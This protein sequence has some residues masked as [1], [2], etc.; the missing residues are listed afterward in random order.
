MNSNFYVVD[1]Y[2]LAQF[3]RLN[4]V[5]ALPPE[6]TSISISVDPLFL[7]LLL[8]SMFSYVFLKNGHEKRLTY[9]LMVFVFIQSYLSSLSLGRM[10]TKVKAC[11]QI[12]FFYLN[13]YAHVMHLITFASFINLKFLQ[14]QTLND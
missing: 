12:Q 2:S 1:F 13:I 14:S 3:R 11:N 6:S 5:K 9:L 7:C 8:F 4:F 10:W